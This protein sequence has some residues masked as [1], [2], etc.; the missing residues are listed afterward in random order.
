MEASHR[1]ERLRQSAVEINRQRVL[2]E[3]DRETNMKTLALHYDGLLAND[4]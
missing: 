4:A 1:N 2:R 3:G